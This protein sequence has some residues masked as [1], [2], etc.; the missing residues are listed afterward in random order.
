MCVPATT[1]SSRSS[2]QESAAMDIDASSVNFRKQE[3][4]ALSFDLTLQITRADSRRIDTY[5]VH[6]A[7]VATGPT[8]CMALESQLQSMM[9]EDGTATS[10]SIDL[11]E[12]AAILVPIVL[13]YIYHSPNFEITT[14]TA[15][16]LRHLAGYFRIARLQEATW[17]FIKKDIQKLENLELYLGE[18][19]YFNDKQTATWVA[20]EC[21]NKIQQIPF[22]SSIWKDLTPDDF[23]QSIKVSRACRT[24]V[25]LQTSELVAMYCSQHVKQLTERTFKEITCSKNLPVVS[26]NAA[27]KLMAVEFQVRELNVSVNTNTHPETL[28]SLQRRCVQALANHQM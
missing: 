1:V 4:R 14:K 16:G 22:S 9:M 13:E 17:Q 21:A 28:S 8:K 11:S 2:S 26:K 20:F 7:I 10:I 18:A 15:V 23:K 12:R 6:K 5:S 3:A 27:L 25:P 19:N 24:G